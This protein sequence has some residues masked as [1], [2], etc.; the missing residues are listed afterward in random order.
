MQTVCAFIRRQREGFVLDEHGKIVGD[1][2]YAAARAFCQ[3]GDASLASLLSALCLLQPAA[4]SWIDRFLPPALVLC[5]RVLPDAS[6]AAAAA[7]GEAAPAELG[8][9]L[10]LAGL[11]GADDGS[12]MVRLANA[13]GATQARVTIDCIAAAVLSADDSQASA[14]LIL[15]AC[16]AR[17]TEF[18]GHIEI[19][20]RR[21][22]LLRAL[23]AGLQHNRADCVAAALAVLGRLAAQGELGASLFDEANLQAMYSMVFA[24]LATDDAAA[25]E[26]AAG[27]GVDAL[28]VLTRVGRMRGVLES[29]S[30]LLRDGLHSLAGALR[31]ADRAHAAL[32]TLRALTVLALASDRLNEAVSVVVCAGDCALLRLLLAFTLDWA[33][34]AERAAAALALVDA[35]VC[36][37]DAAAASAVG[38][39]CEAGDLRLPG[40][41]VELILGAVCRLVAAPA[42]AERAPRPL[43]LAALRLPLVVA[44]DSTLRMKAA[45]VLAAAAPELAALAALCFVA[46][47]AH[48]EGAMRLLPAA[49]ELLALAA[50]ADPAPAPAGQSPCDSLVRRADAPAALLGALAAAA[51]AGDRLSAVLATRWLQRTLAATGS[52]GPAEALS[53][54]LA[55]EPAA[56]RGACEAATAQLEAL[57]TQLGTARLALARA[58]ARDAGAAM[59]VDASFAAALADHT[60]LATCALPASDALTCLIE[61]ARLAGQA[62]HAA[63][64]QRAAALG[65]AEAAEQRA[66]AA[67]QAAASE[68]QAAQAYVSAAREAADAS[69]AEAAALRRELAVRAGEA[70]RAAAAIVRLEKT[71]AAQASAARERDAL[72]QRNAQLEDALGSAA[73]EI[74][75]A[76]EAYAAT[77]A[78]R[79]DFAGRLAQATAELEALMRRAAAAEAARDAAQGEAGRLSTLLAERG[80]VLEALQA[81]VR[82]EEGAAA[83]LRRECAAKDTALSK[84]RQ[85]AATIQ[86]LTAQASTDLAAS[87]DTVRASADSAVFASLGSLEATWDAGEG[88]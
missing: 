33:A 73:R 64:A 46:S 18:C 71:A 7:G 39:A 1:L 5:T 41:A 13:L 3:T 14:A 74:A 80:R 47:H 11:L 50:E 19:A 48:R 59:S 42:A 57:Q 23:V 20:S 6:G 87:A 79:R 69:A 72:A 36:A 17:S 78:A 76:S 9:M 16:L 24:L 37:A 68:A 40:L 15:L 34:A 66:T 52:L 63:E 51:H 60:A 12:R 84:L 32:P 65:R 70:E 27:L 67:E 28:R 61:L 83:A 2:F 21:K 31:T 75:S 43:L 30:A 86:S 55:R 45:R 4:S 62:A 49:L 88:R 53:H 29:S 38:T 8:S 10:V 82:E 58:L 85:V 77:E 44:G 26:A 22:R 54:V 35:L 56:A 25:G 81:R